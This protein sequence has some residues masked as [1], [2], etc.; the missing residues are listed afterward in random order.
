VAASDLDQEW[1]EAL[2]WYD[3]LAED[4]P[5]RP[6][7][8]VGAAVSAQI[9]CPRAMSWMTPCMARDGHTALADDGR[10]VGCPSYNRPYPFEELSRLAELMGLRVDYRGYRGLKGREKAADDL[11]DL[12]AKYALLKESNDG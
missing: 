8:A 11:R 1:A 5:V 2:E 6:Q 12:A 3:G 4:D 10:C 9:D 7:D